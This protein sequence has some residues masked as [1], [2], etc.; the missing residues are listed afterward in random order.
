MHAGW[1]IRKA[2]VEDMDERGRGIARALFT[3]LLRFSRELGAGRV[4]LHATPDGRPLY[5]A[6]GFVPNPT[7]LEWTP[8]QA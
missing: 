8:P 1:S 6:M 7:S 4:L 3:E 2:S 5:E